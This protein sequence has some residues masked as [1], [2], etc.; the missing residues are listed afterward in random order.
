MIK[1]SNHEKEG[2]DSN[3]MIGICSATPLEIY[4]I[5]K[6]LTK[7]TEWGTGSA[8]FFQGVYLDQKIL[9]IQSGIGRK[10]IRRALKGLFPYPEIRLAINIGCTGAIVPQMEIAHINIPPQIRLHIKNGYYQPH[11]EWL[12]FAV[13][14]AI[15]FKRT[16]THFFPA[17]TIQT[18]LDREGK[19]DLHR[20][21]P[22]LGC[23]DLESYYFAQ[24]FSERQIP[25]VIIRAVSDTWNLRLPPIPYLNPSCWKKWSCTPIFSR[26][27]LHILLFH[28]AAIRACWTNQR[29][30]RYFLDRIRMLEV[31]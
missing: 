13:D 4:W 29:F 21:A 5:K 28:L 23:V 27:L 11:H 16:K 25:Y 3:K 6:E 14:T 19:L 18:A 31:E 30:I 1:Q 24:F 9:L 7:V 22:D 12:N 20:K 26:H 2:H 15:S 10:N 8:R 17:L